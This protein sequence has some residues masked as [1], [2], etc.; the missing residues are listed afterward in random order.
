MI[1]K[2]V[3]RFYSECTSSDRADYHILPEAPYVSFVINSNRNQL[4]L[5]YDE[6]GSGSPLMLG[7]LRPQIFDRANEQSLAGTRQPESSA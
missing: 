7:V 3:V 4:F 1:C 5:I 6:S 2:E